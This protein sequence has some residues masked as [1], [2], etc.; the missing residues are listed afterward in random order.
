MGNLKSNKIA[1]GWMIVIAC[2]LIQAIPFGV[3]SNIQPL[4][5]H[6]VTT[7]K[8]F[9]LSSF[10]LIFTIGTIVS[11]V[12]SPFI[13]ALYGKVNAKLIYIVGCLLSGGG[14]MLFSMCTELWQFYLV[15]G[16]VNIG[17]SAISAI[18][19]PLLINSWFDESTKGKA[20]GIAFAGGSIG[21]IFLQQ[22]AIYS[23]A[24]NGYS[25]AYFLFGVL[26]LAVG[27][28]VAL[29]MI[30]MPKN[31]DEIVVGNKKSDKAED[32]KEEKVDLAYTLKEVQKIKY[33]WMM[34]IGFLFVGIYVSA[35]SVQY[36]AYFQ[37]E[38]KLDPSVVAMSGSIFA[39]TSL[40]GN[41]VGG[42]LFDKIGVMKCLVISSVAVFVSGIFLTMSGT[43]PIFAYA[44]SAIK[45]IAVYMY[46]M[47][48]A[49]LTGSFFGRKEYGS[50]LGMIN[51]VFALGF[52]GGSAIFGLF[53]DKFGYNT[54]W[55]GILACVAAAYILLIIASRGMNNL[56][57]D[58][59]QRLEAEKEIKIA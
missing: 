14:F 19:V 42:I 45:G 6:P 31:K 27:I 50:I 38:L 59:R 35:Y 49:Y 32:K 25:R 1:K 48:P 36:A 54:A 13:G 3:A 58:R 55:M 57:K 47:G 18:G 26:S 29:L 9:S 46:M 30:R 16:I 28:P 5:I 23:I 2:M 24:S 39:I 44:F 8:G 53:T 52:S 40:C 37:G 4:F 43:S 51:L 56:N 7:D 10:S 20:M 12:A 21:N 11:A 41:V 22:M 34:A 17:T 15:A 33:F